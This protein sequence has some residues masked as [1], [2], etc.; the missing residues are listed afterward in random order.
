MKLIHYLIA[1]ASKSS[2]F[3]IVIIAIAALFLRLYRF[4]QGEV[5]ITSD[6]VLL[7]EYSM[8]PAYGLFSGNI[9]EFIT[10]LF[11]F[12]NFNWGWGTLAGS[13]IN[14]F[15]LTLF[16]IP[17]TEFTIHFPYVIIGLLSTI[18][19]YFL[20]IALTRSKLI[21][22][23]C[24]FV[25]AILP[26]HV[27]MSRSIAGLAISS[28]LFFFLTLLLFLRYFQFAKTEKQWRG[29]KELFF[30]MIFL[31]VYFCTDNQFPAILP[32]IFTGGL[33]FFPEKNL[34]VRLKNTILPFFSKYV[35][36][37]F[38]TILP[39]VL[40][41]VYLAMEGLPKG[42]YILNLF[43]SK[44]ISL[45]N[46]IFYFLDSVYNNVGPVLLVLFIIS[47]FYNICAIVKKNEYRKERIFV[48]L[49]FIFTATPWLFLLSPEQVSFQIYILQPMTALIVLTGFFIFD[50]HS[51]VSRFNAQSIQTSLSIAVITIISIFTI[52]ST[53][54]VVHRTNYLDWELL[55]LYGSVEQNTGI[56]SAGYYV[57]EKLSFSSVMFSDA[58][59][60]NSQYYF[61][62]SVRILGDIDLSDNETFNTYLSA[63]KNENITHVF[64]T[65]QRYALFD[66]ALQ[67][68]NFTKEV[69]FTERGLEK[70]AL[71]S[72]KSEPAGIVQI[73]ETDII[74]DKK[75]GSL[76]KLYIDFG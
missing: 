68:D 26:F 33:L 54:N 21:A 27:A 37:F 35:L 6:E 60:Y 49:W 25:L 67:N 75:Y 43:H 56:K 63:L 42:S 53:S 71:F 46:R 50:I 19:F 22:F 36:L 20:C 3:H 1:G 69:I 34:S 59:L 74:F 76:E 2:A 45:N 64:V 11:R 18:V 38:L 24:S 65:K 41:A 16:N 44:D 17:I 55:P 62:S 51:F 73:E 47:F 23:F 40:G 48:F 32:L 4:K 31:G 12:F 30:G 52:I 57:R 7:L 72:K 66:N 9:E 61:G 13:A 39:T 28:S 70:S 29:K 5:L 10:Q 14:I 58:E 8:K 15:I